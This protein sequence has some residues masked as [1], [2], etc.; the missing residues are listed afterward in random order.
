MRYINIY[1][2]ILFIYILAFYI[3]IYA[4]LK[5]FY[6]GRWALPKIVFTN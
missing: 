2:Y 4:V 5:I 6:F 1:I 3:Y